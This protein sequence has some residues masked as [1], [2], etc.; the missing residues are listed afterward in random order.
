VLAMAGTG[1]LAQLVFRRLAPGTAMWWGSLM[2]AA[3]VAGTVASLSAESPA[4]FLAAAV[5]TGTGFG[6]GFMGSIRLISTT[7]PLEQRAA[8]MSAFYVV[9]YSSLS[10]PTLIAGLA[11]PELGL[12]QTF[13]IFGSIVVVLGLATAVG[14]RLR[15]VGGSR[16]QDRVEQ[17]GEA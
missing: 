12:E 6:V 11:V 16:L 5:L 14:A 13:R 15:G 7:A 4:L 17:A 9:A 1:G 10:L 3:G 2:L 8:V